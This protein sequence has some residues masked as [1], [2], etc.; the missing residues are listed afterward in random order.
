[1]REEIRR[2]IAHATLSAAGGRH[3][4]ILFSAAVGRPLQMTACSQTVYDHEARAHIIAQGG[5]RL[6]H[7][8]LNAH[9][10][11]RLEGLTFTGY[12]H[13]SKQKFS[14]HVEGQW[15][16]VFD[17]RE[18]RFFTYYAAPSASPSPAPA[19]LTPAA[20]AAPVVP[21]TA[22]PPIVPGGP[23]ESSAGR[24]RRTPRGGAETASR[25]TTAS[26]AGRRRAGGRAKK[27]PARD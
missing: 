6:Y 20:G 19:A 11:F 21:T 27:P 7:A 17:Q 18:K 26:P 10:W 1:M 13:D 3:V 25:R 16:H 4:A 15:V 8:G 9:L 22:S 23:E 14:G 5:G 24:Q 2:V 12:D